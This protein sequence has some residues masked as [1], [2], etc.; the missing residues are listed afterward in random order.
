MS[1][2]SFSLPPAR[3]R[4]HRKSAHEM[5]L[6]G[7]DGKRSF[8]MN[9]CTSGNTK[10]LAIFPFCLVFFLLSREKKIKSNSQF[11][12]NLAIRPILIHTV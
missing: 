3:R 2:L 4:D 5:H 9:L 7:D 8:A 12:T 1:Q 10:M 11:G 6:E